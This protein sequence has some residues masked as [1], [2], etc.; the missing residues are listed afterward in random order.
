[1]VENT[2]RIIVLHQIKREEMLQFAQGAIAGLKVSA[3]IAR[4]VTESYFKLQQIIL[5]MITNL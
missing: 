5:M 4:L 2:Y 3:N 1:M